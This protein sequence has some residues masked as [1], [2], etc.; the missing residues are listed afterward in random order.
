MRSSTPCSSRAARRSP[1]QGCRIDVVTL[2]NQGETVLAWDPRTGDPLTTVVVWQDG[3]AQEVCDDLAEHAELVAAR[4]GLVLDPYFSAPK[5]A[6]VRRH[7][8][9]DGVVTTTDAWLAAPP[10]R[11]ARHGRVDGQPLA[12]D[13]PVDG[14]VGRRAARAVRPRRRADAADRRERRD[15]G[16]DLR[17]S[18][19]TCRSAASWSTS[20]RRCWR[21]GCLAPRRDE[22]HVRHGRLPARERRRAAAAVARRTHHVGRLAACAGTTAYCVDGQVFTAASAV[23][24]LQDLGLVA[25]AAELDAVAADD[26][27]GVLASRPSPASGRRGG[28]PTRRRRSPA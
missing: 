9:R 4:T 1:R 22:V 11:R 16:H 25:S 21:S 7:L 3:R 19:A 2:A 6:W 26:A 14:G 24:W 10:H 13:R 17:P 28:V 12:G 23:R 20:R 15:R 27:G 5:Q 18:A 8:T